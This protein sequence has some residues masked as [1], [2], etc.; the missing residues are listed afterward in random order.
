MSTSSKISP[1]GL[2]NSR[3]NNRV[4]TSGKEIRKIGYVQHA[5]VGSIY[6]V[7]ITAGFSLT[8]FPTF[9][10]EKTIF[11]FVAGALLG[12]AVKGISSKRGD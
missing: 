2:I 11:P 9:R 4:D 6:S 12:T 8:N 10:L 1:Q 3:V 7:A 5:N